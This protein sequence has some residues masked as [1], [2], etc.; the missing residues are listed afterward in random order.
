MHQRQMM[1]IFYHITTLRY[2]DPG[3]SPRP[4][5]SSLAL[6]PSYNLPLF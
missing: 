6:S 2:F 1:T 5:F 4:P 3:S